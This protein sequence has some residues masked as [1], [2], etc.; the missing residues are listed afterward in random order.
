MIL[1]SIREELEYNRERTLYESID[2]KELLEDYNTLL[3]ERIDMFIDMLNE[4]CIFTESFFDDMKVKKEDLAD[5]NK[6]KAI[7]KRIEKEKVSTDVKCKLLN[8]L[9]SIIIALIGIAPG[10]TLANVGFKLGFTMTASLFSGLGAILYMIGGV[11]AGVIIISKYLNRYDSFILKTKKAINKL[12]K[13]IE[14]EKDPA[15]IKVFKDQLNALNK[16]LK[17]FEKAKY[18]TDKENY[19][20]ARVNIATQK[21]ID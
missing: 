18:E 7:I 13:I 4:E 12:E 17:I 14:K 21:S 11:T 5:P 9:Y 16:N 8:T 6:I 1:E 19:K 10:V 20:G 15:K 3:E 2:V